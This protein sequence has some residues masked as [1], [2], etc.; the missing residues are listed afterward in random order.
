MGLEGAT[1]NP[2]HLQQRA[3]GL[4]VVEPSLVDAEFQPR[5]A[6]GPKSV[7]HADGTGGRQIPCSKGR[8][9]AN[10]WQ[11]GAGIWEKLRSGQNVCVDYAPLC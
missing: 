4:A 9:A 1:A 5:P 6:V 3:S 2:L 11:H 10:S 7:T 8:F